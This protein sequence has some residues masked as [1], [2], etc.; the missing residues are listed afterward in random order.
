MHGLSKFEQLQ[1][2]IVLPAK[3]GLSPLQ[4]RLAKSSGHTEGCS[5]CKAHVPQV[6]EQP[7]YSEVNDTS[8]QSQLFA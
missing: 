7:A 5:R 6:C 2:A 8:K 1:E 4:T 3:R